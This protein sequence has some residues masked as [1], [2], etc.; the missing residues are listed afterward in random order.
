M[1]PRLIRAR[2][3][4]IT[5]ATMLAA[6]ARAQVTVAR[7]PIGDGAQLTFGYLC[8]DRFVVRNDGTNPVDLEYSVSRSNEHT[9]LTINGRETVELASKSRE[10]M[11]LW[12][13]GKLVAKAL[14]EKRRCQD[15]QGNAN[16]AVSPLDV[17]TNERDNRYASRSPFY[18][19]WMYGFNGSL[20]FRSYYPGFY[21]G[22]YRAPIVIAYRGGGRRGH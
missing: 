7:T 17:R 19:P 3:L 10:A 22:F 20:G 8:D 15:V 11:E 9:K 14:K 2:M 12:I 1:T 5:A 18:D 4:L 21:S 13:D 6:T 16:V